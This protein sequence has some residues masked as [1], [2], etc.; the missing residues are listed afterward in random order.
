M[1][2]IVWL[3]SYPKSGNTWIRFMIAD[4]VAG[5]MSSS[6]QVMTQVPDIHEGIKGQHLFGNHTTVVKTHWK[7]WTGI[8]L[9]EDTI[10]IV[11]I[12]RNPIDV[13]ES[14]QNYAFHRSGALREE[15]GP[16][17]ISRFAARWVDEYLAHGGYPRFQQFGIGSW[18]ENVRGWTWRGLAVPRLLVRYEELLADPTLGLA[19]IAK[20]LGISR[21]E[22]Q[23]RRAI[24]RCSRERMRAI[25]EREIAER[26]EGFFYQSR[27][28]SGLA[29]GHRF[30]GRSVDGRPLFRL[31]DEQ[32]TRAKERFS[33]IMQ[34][35]GY[36]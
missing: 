26:T 24:E 22:E 8:P 31:T 35:F 30:V 13:L 28:S 14:N 2:K 3:A 11:Y 33:P 18:E 32:R 17:E 29:A 10:G 34:E 16:E 4:L 6:A 5:E 7:Y 36:Q 12:V 21:S 23:V 20:F 15:A 9:R 1:A 19:R 27:N 25:E